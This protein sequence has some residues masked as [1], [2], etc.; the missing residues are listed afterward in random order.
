MRPVTPVVVL[1]EGYAGATMMG[2]VR[3]LGRLR[4]PVSVFSS[5]PHSPARFSRYCRYHHAPDS[6]QQADALEKLLIEHAK[7]S[8]MKPLLFP[9]GDGEVMFLAES[10]ERLQPY[11]RFN[12]ACPDLIRAMANKRTQY[13]IVAASDLSIPPTYFGINSANASRYSVE[14]PVV[15][16]PVYAHL[17]PW[18]GKTKALSAENCAELEKHLKEMER[19]GIE[20]VVQSIIP[21]PASELYTIAA[22]ISKAGEAV[23]VGSLRKVRHY[24]LDFGF[25]SLNEAV[26]VENLENQIVRFLCDI[27]FRGVC[28]VEFKRDRRDG[29]FR[30]IEINPRFELAHHLLS[31]AGADVA[32]AM[33][34]DLT[35]DEL[36]S[37]TPYRVGMRW[38]SLSLDL[39]ACRALFARGDLSFHSWIQ[40]M[41]RVRTEALLTW[42][43]PWPGLYS[44]GRTLSSAFFPITQKLNGRPK[45]RLAGER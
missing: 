39:K 34:A 22:Y 41:C 45:Y 11:Y 17:W 16:K 3:S 1:G 33:Y 24:P 28:G 15:I 42:D 43:D 35:G 26:R 14:F 8:S 9:V 6:V 44:Y 20:V 37:T 12:Q 21:G 13:E 40:S 36:K 5:H 19:R 25:G 38:I 23:A 30:L 29:R 2:V 32:T 27:G 4:I 31:T 7:E 18:R 10:R